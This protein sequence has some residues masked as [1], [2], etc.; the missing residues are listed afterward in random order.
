MVWDTCLTPPDPNSCV[1]GINAHQNRS[2]VTTGFRIILR[3]HTVTKLGHIQ[4]S[5]QD[6]WTT[7]HTRCN[8]TQL[9]IT[10]PESVLCRQQT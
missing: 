5:G 9:P 4:N 8:C 7:L 2:D 10:K 1:L 6:I 3:K